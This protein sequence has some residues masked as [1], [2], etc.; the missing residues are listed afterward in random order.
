MTFVQTTYVWGR[1]EN[2]WACHPVSPHHDAHP[3]EA[4]INHTLAMQ[5]ARK[6]VAGF[7]RENLSFHVRTCQAS[8]KPS[9]DLFNSIKSVL[10]T[11]PLAN[12]WRQSLLRL[13]HLQRPWYGTMED[14]PTKNAMP[15]RSALCK[16]KPRLWWPL[17]PL[18]VL[19]AR[20]F[21]L[22]HMKC[23]VSK[24]TTKKWAGWS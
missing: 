6:F 23:Q 17:M 10:F 1:C 18:Q 4:D 13:K 15:F 2:S 11:V 21:A 22:L 7:A 12:P 8:Y 20:T 3:M 9:P 14:Y 5:D 16:A 19:T 24:P